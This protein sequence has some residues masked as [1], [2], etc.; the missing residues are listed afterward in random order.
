MVL[1]VKKSTV[2]PKKRKLKH[3]TQWLEKT[4]GVC[5][6]H[7]KKKSDLYPFFIFITLGTPWVSLGKVLYSFNQCAVTISF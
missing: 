1:N 6:Q 4:S 5:S 2:L 3:Q 7:L